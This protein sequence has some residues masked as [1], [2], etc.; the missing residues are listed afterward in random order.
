M[1]A[2]A[3]KGLR[4]LELDH[5]GSRL[6]R[7]PTALRRLGVYSPLRMATQPGCAQG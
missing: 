4:V 1:Y 7:S 6:W 5:E 3:R 2:I